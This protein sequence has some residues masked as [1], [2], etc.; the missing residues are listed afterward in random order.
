MLRQDPALL[1]PEMAQGFP[2]HDADVSVKQ[3]GIVRRMKLQTTG[4]VFTLRPAVGMP[5]MMARTEAVE[6]AFSRRQ[7]G[8]RLTLWPLSLA[9]MPCSGIG[10][11]WPA[12][13]RRC[14][15]PP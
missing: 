15:A 1:P 14:G 8:G 13:V 7:W 11:G 3:D 12:A 6:K 4:A 5:D 10:P 9:A 2:L